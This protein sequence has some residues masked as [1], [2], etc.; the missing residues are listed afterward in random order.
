MAWINPLFLGLLRCDM[1]VPNLRR[2]IAALAAFSARERQFL[3]SSEWL[4]VETPGYFYQ[5]DDS[6]SRGCAHK[7]MGEVKYYIYDSM[8]PFSD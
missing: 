1:S 3:S 2:T 5:L 4:S 8:S 7:K 6:T